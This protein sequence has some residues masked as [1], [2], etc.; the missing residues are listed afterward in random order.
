MPLIGKQCVE[1]WK[2]YN[3]DWEFRLL[4]NSNLTEYF[5]VDK[6]KGVSTVQAKSDVLRI[7]LLADNGG[8]WVD[9]DVWCCKPLDE[10]VHGA[11]SLGGFFA[12]HLSNTKRIISSWFLASTTDNYLTKKYRDLVREYWDGWNK[13]HAYFWF[14]F[15]FGP[16][17]DSDKRVQKIW[18]SCDKAS[19][20]DALFFHKRENFS[21]PKSLTSDVYDR[22][23]TKKEFVYKLDRRHERRLKCLLD[24]L[25]ELKDETA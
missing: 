23:R 2:T 15:L 7:N 12:F 16:M 6:W 13:S 14:H 5:D 1:S 22:L 19:A 20:W 18:D 10:W 4:D 24:V 9:V 8:V 11:N 25:N 21:G 17:C 3:K